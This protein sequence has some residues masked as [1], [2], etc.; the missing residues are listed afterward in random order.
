MNHIWVTRLMVL[1][2]IIVKIDH[3]MSRVIFHLIFLKTTTPCTMKWEKKE[4]TTQQPPWVET[5]LPRLYLCWVFNYVS[6]KQEV[7]FSFFVCALEDSIPPKAC[8]FKIV[9]LLLPLTM[10][11]EVQNTLGKQWIKGLGFSAGPFKSV[12]LQP[13]YLQLCPEV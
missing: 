8:V 2:Q 7:I 1:V 9:R 12:Q 6:W 11:S 4:F 13:M 5:I 10:G 3:S